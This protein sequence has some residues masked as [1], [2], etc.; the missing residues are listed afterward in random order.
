MEF[1]LGFWTV[2]SLSKLAVNATTGSTITDPEPALV[3]A[4]VKPLAHKAS[5]TQTK[6]RQLLVFITIPMSSLS[7]DN[8]GRESAPC[9]RRA[10][11]RN[12]SRKLPA[13]DRRP[14]DCVDA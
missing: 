10:I 5:A 13:G 14:Q 12:R 7:I 4:C 6:R 11:D 3:C 1:A 8:Y 9:V 2:T